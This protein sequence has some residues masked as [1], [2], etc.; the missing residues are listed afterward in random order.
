MVGREK[1][2]ALLHETEKELK[3]LEFS[4]EQYFL[5]IE[6]RSPEER[7]NKFALRLRKLNALY[8]PQTD[9]LFR[10]KGLA[11]RFNSFCSYWDRIQRQIDEG[12]YQRH[13]SRIERRLI[14][15]EKSSQALDKDHQKDSIDNLYEKLVV[16]HQVC[17]M[18]PPNRDQVAKFLSKQ[19][20]TIKKKFG[21][22]N[23]D[24]V[25][26]TREGKPKIIVR[27]QN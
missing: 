3:G 22:N 13:T 19:A 1:I 26:T 12:R 9:L 11:G 24:F 10:L 16:A 8:I 14:K 7:R 23:I 17:E 20:E 27:S 15:T 4:Y 18:R 5:G 2:T 21:N 6:K 25:V